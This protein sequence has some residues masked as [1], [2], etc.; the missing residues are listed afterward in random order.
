MIDWYKEKTEVNAEG[1]TVTYKATN[2]PV[3]IESQKRH[4]PHANSS[5]TWDY[6]SFHVFWFREKIAV[7]NSLKDAKAFA[8]K[9]MEATQA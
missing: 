5:G 6:T 1:T 4:I 9:Y 8:E 3:T 7:K 2:A